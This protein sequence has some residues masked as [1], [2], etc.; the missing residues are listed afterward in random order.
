[1]RT[2]A[3][4]LLD[5]LPPPGDP[6]T[7][8]ML[9]NRMGGNNK[10]VSKS[11]AILRRRGLVE[12]LDIGLYKLTEQGEKVRAEGIALKNG[13]R[14]KQSAPHRR[15]APFREAFWRALRL[16]DDAIT[17]GDAL[18]L[19]PE[20]IHGSNPAHNAHQYLRRLIAA[21]YVKAMDWREPGTAVTSNGFKRYR[22]LKNT[23]P[24]APFWSLKDGKLI[25][26][27]PV[28]EISNG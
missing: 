1:M 5:A 20:E 23:G 3:E 8:A 25:D 24:L 9:A 26:L 28:K 27:N 13:P 21:G 14:K 2:F 19:I 18:S 15:T 22:L 11:I 7:I 4:E 10:R 12:R 17:I 16:S 6:V